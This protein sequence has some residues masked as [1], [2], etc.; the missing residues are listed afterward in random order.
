MNGKY[1]S[2]LTRT[3]EVLLIGGVILAILFCVG[4]LR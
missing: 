4:A 1:P 3:V 2:W